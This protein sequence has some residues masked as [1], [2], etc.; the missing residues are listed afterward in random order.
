MVDI[1]YPTAF[2]PDLMR[3]AIAGLD[4]MYRPGYRYKKAG[5]YLSKITAGEAVQPD[6]FGVFSPD[7]HH[8][9]GRFMFIVDAI[10]RIYGANTLFFAAQGLARPWAMH[11]R[12][13]SQHFTT[14]WNEILTI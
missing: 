10:N 9:Q 11:Q 6:L 4:A 2:T 14:R 7:T 5:V 13:L 1:A 3:Y 12:R 8:R